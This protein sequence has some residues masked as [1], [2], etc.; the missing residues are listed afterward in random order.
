MKICGFAIY[1]LL[2][3]RISML[4]HS[5]VWNNL[6]KQH[7]NVKPCLLSSSYR[8]WSKTLFFPFTGVGFGSDPDKLA[9][10]AEKT[11]MWRVGYYLRRCGDGFFSEASVKMCLSIFIQDCKKKKKSFLFVSG[12]FVWLVF[13]LS[14]LPMSLGYLVWEEALA[15]LE[16][17]SWDNPTS[18]N[19]S[20]HM[21]TV[22]LAPFV[23]LCFSVFG[24][25]IFLWCTGSIQR[26]LMQVKARPSPVVSF[27]AVFSWQHTGTGK[28]KKKWR[29]DCNSSWILSTQVPS[30][31]TSF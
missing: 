31:T 13:L 11:T 16:G 6:S 23:L 9:F 8:N 30:S 27:H 24:T 29:Q 3:A 15:V 26:L 17:L 2:P 18:S 20:L 5:S 14:P 21:L 22:H 1:E 12:F 19:I 28:T 4:E 10:L 25:F 7:R